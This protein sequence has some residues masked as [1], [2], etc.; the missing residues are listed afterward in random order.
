MYCNRKTNFVGVVRLIIKKKGYK[1]A[2]S[3]RIVL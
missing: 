2:M 3:H 1:G